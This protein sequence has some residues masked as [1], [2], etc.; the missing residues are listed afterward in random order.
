MTSFAG[1]LVMHVSPCRNVGPNV[2]MS[3]EKSAAG[4]LWSLPSTAVLN[5]SAGRQQKQADAAAADDEAGGV[6]TPESSGGSRVPLGRAVVARQLGFG[7]DAAERP[8]GEG[9]DHQ[10]TQVPEE[11]RG[12]AG[13]V[14]SGIQSGFQMAA[15][16]GAVVRLR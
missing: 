13:A 12:A 11:F 1:C 4:G 3:S 14:E 16:A 8:S 7:D 6:S 15:A 2:L 9:S 5:L 10:A